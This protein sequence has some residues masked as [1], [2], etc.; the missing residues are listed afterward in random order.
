MPRVSLP[1]YTSLA[2]VALLCAACGQ[3]YEEL[4]ISTGY[5][6]V[7]T[8]C[9]GSSTVPGIDVSKWQGTVNWGA[10]KAAGKQFGIA[11]ISDG[12]KYNDA[13]FTANWQGMKAAGLIRGS[14]QY[15]RPD[16]D[17]TAQANLVL[18]KLKAAGGLQPGDLP[19]VLDLETNG[20]KSS[21]TIIKNVE[22]WIAKIKQGTNRVPM[23]YT[24]SYFWDGK[25]I[26]SKFASYPLWTAHYTSKPCPLV[27][28]PWK[29]WKIWQ[30]TS[31]EQV[32]GVKG[33]VDANRFNGTLAQLK[34]FA[35][36]SVIGPQPD[37]G[38]PKPD[39]GPPKPDLKPPKPDLKPPKPDQ[40]RK[41]KGSPRKD[42]RPHLPDAGPPPRL[43]GKLPPV[44]G[45]PAMVLEGGCA[46]GIGDRGL[47]SACGLM[48]LLALILWRRRHR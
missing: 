32:N 35:A 40:G 28:N 27:P 42:S 17:P 43:D 34:A 39:Q 19:V 10:V 44:A 18:S 1:N 31:K 38:P 48:L 20:G 33:G 25:V 15:F 6:D 47:G 4:M 36:S 21:A 12:I 11:R 30:Y 24:G 22:T 41:D 46:V 37:S 23:I 14:Y 7:H 16:V 3:D 8:V 2:L 45:K 29:E 13:Y 9:G 26:T 5:W